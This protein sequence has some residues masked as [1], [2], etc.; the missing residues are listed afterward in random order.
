MENNPYF[1]DWLRSI[2]SMNKEEL[3][4]IIE[5]GNRDDEYLELA[6]ER[7]AFLRSN[8][9]QQKVWEEKA[10]T[11]EKKITKAE[12]KKEIKKEINNTA[13]DTLSFL[14]VV[15]LIIGIIGGIALFAISADAS[16]TEAHILIS[17]AIYAII[18]SLIS[19]ASLKV[20]VNISKTLKEINY[21]LSQIKD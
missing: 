11:T 17:V 13:D 3:I 9:T 21:R 6:R 4:K 14:A 1:K 2:E 5:E 7:L 10:E 16:S 18:C 8:N 19:W 20:F 15:T 12:F